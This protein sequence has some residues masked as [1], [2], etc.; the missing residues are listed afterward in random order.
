MA[1]ES[2]P[3]SPVAVRTAS[4]L[5]GDWIR[6]TGEIWVEGQISELKPRRSLAWITLRDTDADMSIPLKAPM[7]AV[8]AGLVAEGHR[9]VARVRADYWVKNG[10]ISWQ[11]VEFRPV[12]IGAL[13]QRLEELRRVLAAEGLFRDERKRPLPLLPRRIGLVCGRGSAARHDVEVNARARW[14]AARFEVREVAVQGASAVTAMSAAIA[15]LDRQA[16]VDVIVVTRGGGSFEDLLPFSNEALIRLVST[17]TTPVVSAIGHEEDAPL[18]DS[19]ADRRASTPTAAGKMVVPDLDHELQ[20]VRSHRSRLARLLSD[21]LSR[22]RHRLDSLVDR[23]VMASPLQLLAVA[24]ERVAESDRR[25]TSALTGLLLTERTRLQGLRQRPALTRPDHLTSQ[26]RAD[27]GQ[28]AARLRAMS[29]AATLDRGYAIVLAPGP[30]V[31]HSVAGVRSGAALEVRLSDG[32][33]PVTV[34][35]EPTPM[36]PE[37]RSSREPE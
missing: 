19:V 27:T 10:S 16:D 3:E 29:P 7:S 24:R 31:V 28:L 26:R 21:R 37:H 22:E 6:R 12:G 8:T 9:V 1:L 34:T 32:S 13:M 5:L 25:T 20:Y 23:P 30:K 36:S 11:A 15:E 18:L 35:A 2:S 14:P 17:C 4:R 33:F